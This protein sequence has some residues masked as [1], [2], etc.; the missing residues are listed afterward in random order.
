LRKGFGQLAK[1]RERT[2]AS[3]ILKHNKADR[4][5]GA[6]QKEQPLAEVAD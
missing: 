4:N 2:F 1:R 5:G 6:P 3:R